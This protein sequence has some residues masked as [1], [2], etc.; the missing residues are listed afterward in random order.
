M[1]ICW[2]E[3]FCYVKN[4]FVDSVCEIFDFVLNVVS[5]ERVLF[6]SSVDF[7]FDLVIF[8]QISF[9][10]SLF[11]LVFRVIRTVFEYVELLLIES[12]VVLIDRQSIRL[13][14]LDYRL[15]EYRQEVLFEM[16]PH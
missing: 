4:S 2:H 8:R 14:R 11:F 7:Q 5:E 3:S 15:R 9:C 12:N 10:V 6:L 1:Y 13:I 16:F